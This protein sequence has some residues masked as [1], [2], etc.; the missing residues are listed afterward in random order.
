MLAVLIA[1]L[2]VAARTRLEIPRVEA[3]VTSVALF[4]NG[5]GYVQREARLP[6]GASVVEIEL[7]APS[8]GTFLTHD[9]AIVTLV[10][11]VARRDVAYADV[12]AG[13]VIELLGANVG[14]D[15]ELLLEGG[16]TLSGVVQRVPRQ[17]R[18]PQPWGGYS[19]LMPPELVVLAT[20]GGTVALRVGDV[21]RVKAPSLE[22][23]RTREVAVLAL[24]LARPLAREAAIALT[25]LERGWSWMPSY[26]LEI[27]AERGR[28]SARAEV[29]AEAD[30]L[31]GATVRFV[32]G[33]PNLRHAHVTDPVAFQG[34]LDA[35]LRSLARSP[36]ESHGMTR[37]LVSFQNN[38]SVEAGAVPAVLPQELAGLDVGDLF[39]SERPGV[40]LGRGERALVTLFEA[41]IALAHVYRWKIEAARSREDRPGADGFWHSVRLANETAQPWTSGT[42]TITRDGLLL[43][44]DVLAYTAAGGS[45]TVPVTRAIDLHGERRTSEI[46]RERHPWGRGYEQLVTLHEELHLSS[47]EREPVEVEVVRE[48]AGEV[49]VAP[50]GARHEILGD[51]P[52]EVNRHE[53]LTWRLTL[54]PG[55]T[56][57]LEYDF[58]YYED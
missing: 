40:T 19:H 18:V 50:D 7:P 42:V 29:F 10:S 5:Y 36:E 46:G 6:A 8:L 2:A 39:V 47:Y 41:D 48:L 45:A 43:G 35:F 49:V 16:E 17:E 15:L 33:F 13:S 1:A 53:R 20:T 27:G 28:L 11:A 57:T 4:K 56:R 55:G 25:S 58:R 38:P 14:R 23:R 3:R 26:A 52:S 9:P 34:D 51:R 37:Q 22:T 31:D 24:A 44:Q 32:T 21:K 12:P 54:E 30:A